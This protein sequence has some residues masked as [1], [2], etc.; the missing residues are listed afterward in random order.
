MQL[1][2][3]VSS[4]KRRWFS[5]RFN[6]SNIITKCLT[7]SLHL[8]FLNFVLWCSASS[9]DKFYLADMEL[10]QCI[11]AE[12][13]TCVIKD[14]EVVIILA[15]EQKGSWC[16]LLKNKV[17]W[18]LIWELL[19][20]L[21]IPTVCQC[22][23]FKQCFCQQ[24]NHVS[25]DFEHWEDCEDDSPFQGGKEWTSWCLYCMRWLASSFLH[26]FYLKYFFISDIYDTSLAQTLWKQMTGPLIAN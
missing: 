11:L 21:N 4:L 2:I 26:R 14:K 7:V 16:K 8:I 23:Y 13:S 20:I 24:N 6:K 17:K 22:K 9:G 3:N 12:K 5:G 15:K 19:R 1:T 18:K 25:L 10:H